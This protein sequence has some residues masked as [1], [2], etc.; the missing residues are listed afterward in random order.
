MRV[1]LARQTYPQMVEALLIQRN[2]LE[3]FSLEDIACV[4]R[5]YTDLDTL[6]H[7]RPDKHKH[8]H[9]HTHTH[10]MPDE[11]TVTFST[12]QSS[13]NAG[14]CEAAVRV[15]ANGTSDAVVLTRT[16]LINV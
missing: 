15:G 3:R 5:V 4:R 2:D 7:S 10:L 8:M 6:E 1:T 12:R 13:V 11:R 9:T 14:A 16:A